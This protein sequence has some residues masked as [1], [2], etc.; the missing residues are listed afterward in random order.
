MPSGTV[1]VVSYNDSGTIRV[2]LFPEGDA[3]NVDR[4]QFWCESAERRLPVSRHLATALGIN[5]AGVTKFVDGLDLLFNKLWGSDAIIVVGG[6]TVPRS[7]RRILQE[8]VPL[9]AILV[10]ADAV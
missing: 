10:W 8:L 6:H 1:R 5:T 4:F 3:R 9:H 7:L 2:R